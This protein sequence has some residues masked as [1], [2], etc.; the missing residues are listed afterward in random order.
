M[1]DMFPVGSLEQTWDGVL[2]RRRHKELAS[3]Y[4]ME[5]MTGLKRSCLRRMTESWR[6]ARNAHVS[7]AYLVGNLRVSLR[8]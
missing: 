4:L 7:S 6:K 1:S 5:G 2:G 3:C 8:H